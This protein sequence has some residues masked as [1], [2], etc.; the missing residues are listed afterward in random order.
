METPQA[1]HS[2]VLTEQNKTTQVSLVRQ[3]TQPAETEILKSAPEKPE[4]T[5]QKPK[6]FTEAVLF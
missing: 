2:Q 6:H 5:F 3:L 4:S 1:E